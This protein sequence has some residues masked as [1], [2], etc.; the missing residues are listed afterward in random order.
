MMKASVTALYALLLGS[1]PSRALGAQPGVAGSAESRATV[2]PTSNQGDDL[3]QFALAGPKGFGFA[4]QDGSFN[5]IL[6]WLLQSDFRSFLTN[7]PTPERDTFIVRFAGFRL[8][9]ILYRKVRA[10]LFVNFAESRVTLFDA[11]LEADFA[12][13]F[14]I[15]VGKFQFPITEERLTPAT[16]LPFVS[17]AVA[18]LLLPS[19]DT[20]VQV[21]GTFASGRLSFNLA[22]T[23]GAVAGTLGDSDLDSQKDV[24]ARL[25]ARP[26]LST[27]PSPLQQLGIGVG[28]STG[29][30]RGTLDNPQLPIFLT[31]GGQTFF[32]F[33]RDRAS[34]EVA[35]ASGRVQRIAPHATW[36]WG[37]VA[38]YADAV[39]TREWV[40]GIEVN[41][42]SWSV[43]PTVV[44]TGERAAPL[45]F[46]VP[47]HPLD[48]TKGYL[49]TIELVGGI[50][51]LRVGSSAFPALANPTT[52]MQTFHVY[53]LGLNWF[54]LSG[55]AIIVSYGHQ[56]FTAAGAAPNRPNED[57]LIV[58]AQAVL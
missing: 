10:Q 39:W 50:G 54:P 30:H 12:D 17:T 33:R 48:L 11:F 34:G 25:Y 26:F 49:G 42:N 46:V 51:H 43:I 16:N 20:G 22:L 5:L 38:A 27:G 44:L 18:S 24:V 13:W 58:R 29:V 45:S 36:S 47:A 1:L 2:A 23:N 56:T 14:R 53:G 41:I 35:I 9:A 6:H 31:Y 32:S 55:L 15:R 7:L 37:P 8:D 52:A 28:A 57:T 40:N 21:F 19:R 4:S 3:P